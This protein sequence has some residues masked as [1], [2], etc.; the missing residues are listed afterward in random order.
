MGIIQLIKIK[1][2]YPPYPVLEGIDAE[3]FPG[4]RIGLVGNNGC[5]KTTLFKIIMGILTPDEGE[6]VCQRGLRIAYLPQTAEL[7]ENFTVLESALQGYQELQELEQK[8]AKIQEQLATASMA[9]IPNLV[10]AQDRLQAQYQHT[11]GYRYKSNTETVLQALGFLPQNFGQ[12]IRELS[13]GQ[14]NRL[15]L[16]RTLLQESDLL[17]LDE[18]TN[19]LD[20]EGIEWL[21]EYLA[22]ARQAM[23]IVSHDRYFLNRVTNYT[24]ELSQGRVNSYPGNYDKFLI[25]KEQEVER[26][27]ELYERQQAEIRRQEDFVQRNIYG[28]RHRSAQSRRRVLEKMERLT[29]PH[30]DHDFRFTITTNDTRTNIILDVKDLQHAYGDHLLFRDLS[31]V[32]NAGEKLAIMGPNG[33][34]KSTLLHIITQRL[35][36]TQGQSNIG[37]KVQVGFYHQELHDLNLNT[38][39]FDTI[40]QFMPTSDDVVVRTYLGSF[41][42]QGDDIYKKVGTLSGGE[43]S[44]LALAKLIIQKPNFLVLDEPT[45]HLDIRSRH[46]LECA[47]DDFEGTVLFVSHDRYFI[48]QIAQRLL[49][50]H[51]HRWIAFHGDYSTFHAV[52]AELLPPPLLKT[53]SEKKQSLPSKRPS[54][55]GTKPKRKKKYTLEDL[56]TRIINSEARIHEI[57]QQWQNPTTY[58]NPDLVKS[59]KEEYERLQTELQELNHE[60]ETWAS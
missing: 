32:L 17:L 6:V 21:E 18:P 55:P 31:F 10:N 20:I 30:R 43:K 26:E 59:L 56:E 40:K 23:L 22:N 37:Q 28:E 51:D 5:G 12:R 19:F 1:K 54:S 50:Y 29:A 36:P 57:Q 33:C 25:L 38:T 16:A 46:A 45:N 52:K 11:G 60:W 24:W 7:D 48:D 8:I 13:G 35:A 47:L 58:Q 27:Q 3:I 53:T 39:V 41:L 15:S 34:G 44:R 42:F 9:E 4:N 49:Y 2:S 14:K